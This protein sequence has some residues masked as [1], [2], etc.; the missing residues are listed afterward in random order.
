M[1]DSILVIGADGFIGRHVVRALAERGHATI[2]VSR[3]FGEQ[4]APNVEHIE[5]DLCDTASI[6]PVIARSR[7]VVHLASVSTPG[8]S[9]G[10]PLA[11]LENLRATLALIEALQSRPGVELLYVSSGGTLYGDT[12]Q[13]AAQESGVLRPKSYYGA[14]KAAAEHFIEA[15]CAQFGGAATILR[16]SNVY[17]PG[18]YERRG[19]GIVPSA[20]G[21]LL[22]GE[23]LT[24]WGDGSAERDYLYIDDLVA[25]CLAILDTPMPVGAH[26]LNAASG[27]DTS[28]TTLLET[29]ES[30]V[31]RTLPRTHVPQRAVDV[32]RIAL[33]PARAREAY[34]WSATTPL[35]E[36]IRRTW[37]WFDTIRH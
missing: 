33:D 22:R 20:M 32:A 34:G 7:A 17:G 14:G 30:A 3:R 8:S 9:A 37:A 26:A 15:W 28:L 13:E 11:E 10:Q 24:I 29:I 16:P 31:G 23:S 21:K 25:L 4:I 18:Q 27:I 5:V 1:T 19:F 2:A 12:L 35:A 6:L 36:G